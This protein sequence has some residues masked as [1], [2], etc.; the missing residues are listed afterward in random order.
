VDITKRL[1]E[2]GK[3]MG[4]SVLDHLIIAGATYIS[5]KEMHLL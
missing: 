4:V 5:L 2:A 3:I 1:V